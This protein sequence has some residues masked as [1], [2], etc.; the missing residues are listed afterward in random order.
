[1]KLSTSQLA[2]HLHREIL[3]VYALCGDAPLLVD[4]AAAQIR[5]A[6]Q[7]AGAE[8]TVIEAS[9]QFR[10]A[11]CFAQ[12]DGL[13]LFAER[14]LIEVRLP[15]GKPGVEGAKALETWAT[16]PPPDCTLLLILPRADKALQGSKWFTRLE[17]AGATVMVTTPSLE[18]L[19]Q[20][21]GERLARHQLKADR[22]TLDWLAVRVEGNLLAAHQEIE[23]L[24]L[25]LP[26]GTVT[27]ETARAAV[28]DVARYDT[29]DLPEALWRGDAPRFLRI[30]DSLKAEG[31]APIFA[32]WL[33]A[34]DLRTLYRLALAS[35]R[36]ED[37]A[38]LMRSLRIWDSRQA[39]FSRQAKR[40]GTE[41]LGRALQHAGRID[42]ASKG[43]LRED[44]WNLY[45]QL[46]LALLNQPAP[47]FNT[48][49]PG[50]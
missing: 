16:N 31:E 26:P 20:W 30:A 37:L 50:L 35:A 25:L 40:L 34:Q 18:Q 39:L 3:P 10:W 47:A 44:G 38:G 29:A 21:I 28:T 1:M 27:L 6:L 14:R 49:Q 2:S 15:S 33:L 11:E 32:L 36:G 19:P 8:R 46:G 48:L 7:S 43:L 42:R 24:A 5:R 23:K 45:K 4:E 41:Q 9:A 13:S 17:T 22:A 12:F